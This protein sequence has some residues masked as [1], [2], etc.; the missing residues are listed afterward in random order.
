M[1]VKDNT[2]KKKL[3][4]VALNG[5]LACLQTWAQQPAELT[6]T[7]A[8]VVVTSNRP[9]DRLREVQIGVEKVNIA[10]MAKVPVLL[11]ERDI[12]K[13]VQLLPGVKQESDMSS[14]YQVRGGTSSQNLLLLDDA[15]V[16]NAGHLMGL[17]STFNDDALQGASLYKG[18]IPAQFGGATSSVFDIN[19]KAGDNQHH[20]F[21]GTIG[22]LSAKLF[23]EGP[24]VKDKLSYAVA[25]RR[26][27]M[28]VFLSATEDYK[29]N[30]LNF[31]D[32]NGRLDFRAGQKDFL[33][34]TLFNGR[35]NLGLA[36]MM[37]MIWSNT[38]AVGRWH[39]DFSENLYN[40]LS[41]IASKYNSDVSINILKTD[42]A[43]QGYIAHL[44]LRDDLTWKPSD[45]HRLKFGLQTDWLSLKSAEWDINAL[46]QKES[47]H[48]WENAVWVNEEWSATDRLEVSVGLR[49]NAFSVMGGSPLY[50]IGQ[51]GSVIHTYEEKSGKIVKTYVLLEPR[52]SVNY[53]LGDVG[54]V[55]AGLS[56]TSQNIHAIRN[57]SSS[58]PFDRYTMSS[59]IVKPQTATQVSLGYMGM[60]TNGSY[61]FSIEG[62]YKTV[63]NVYD[64]KDGKTF[65][66]EIEIERIIL[67]GKGR[68][69]G[70]ETMLRKNSGPLTGWVAYTLSW[71]ENKI[72]GINGG[73]W[74]TA[75]HDR[76]HDVSVV[77]MYK[78][79]HRWELSATWV[80][81]TGQAMT[82]PA[83][84]YE[85]G[86]ETFYY[87]AERNGYRAP[88]YHHLDIGAIYTRKSRKFTSQWAF[89]I[90]N[91]YN[92]YN[93]FA[94]TFENDKSKP[95]GTKATQ[96]SLFGI[97]PSVS[98]TLKF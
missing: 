46:H 67:G 81:N 93:P 35:D 26:S 38:S 64:Y 70:V 30:T 63:D 4:L 96:T 10:E 97:V 54:S 21:S 5:F 43:M 7:L 28:D 49:L 82:V 14:G 53:S 8:G 87:Y 84:K 9:A 78:L 11:G 17:F 57:T 1:V 39:H 25:A 86:G 13:S 94:V 62:Y 77:G 19:T 69:Y 48:A 3:L 15:P 41:V 55:K 51:D 60:T 32:L 76:R 37:S 52:L 22:L 47:R 74:Y 18:M 33:T 16:Y 71:A 88:A 66:S 36:D 24:V 85:V 98:Y 80:Y 90:Y 95:S 6:D 89:G 59:N 12:I 75:S 61:D 2:K 44:S 92:H 50:E 56:R 27:Y 23:A 34:L 73:R 65:Y 42:Y 72:D 20:H 83:A 45:N 68:A 40:G 79:N 58:M 31:Y 91:V 29:D